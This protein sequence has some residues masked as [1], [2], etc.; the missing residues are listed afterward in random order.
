MAVAGA[1]GPVAVRR[2]AAPEE[3]AVAAAGA[4]AEAQTA[5]PEEEAVA[6]A[7]AAAE[8]Q[9][10]ARRRPRREATRGGRSSGGHAPCR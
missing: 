8:A 7:G 9:T 5:A 1:A 10:A 2:A 6:A 3:E 4:A